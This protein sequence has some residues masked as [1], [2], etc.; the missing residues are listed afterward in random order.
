MADTAPTFDGDAVLALWEERLLEERK[1][2]VALREYTAGS[3]GGALVALAVY[4][5]HPNALLGALAVVMAVLAG[6]TLSRYAWASTGDRR[7]HREAVER[8]LMATR[9]VDEVHALADALGASLQARSLKLPA[10]VWQHKD[11]TAELQRSLDAKGLV[12]DPRLF[13]AL[14]IAVTERLDLRGAELA[15]RRAEAEARAAFA[16]RSIADL[17]ELEQRL[18]LYTTRPP[19]SPTPT[20]SRIDAPAYPEPTVLHYPHDGQVPFAAVETSPALMRAVVEGAQLAAE[21]GKVVESHAAGVMLSDNARWAPHAAPFKLTRELMELFEP[22]QRDA[23]APLLE[24]QR[25]RR[26]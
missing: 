9:A 4:L 25:Q 21:E 12:F 19:G 11:V 26:G 3:V 7:R 22:S 24:E 10:A 18:A 5:V 2:H 15:A 14:A 20:P 17:R 8:F 23:L 1:R 13:A 16:D 6:V